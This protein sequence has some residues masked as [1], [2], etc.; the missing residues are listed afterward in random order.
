MI[1]VRISALLCDSRLSDTTQ[2]VNLTFPPPCPA[3]LT[4]EQVNLSEEELACD[5]G[6]DVG[7]EQKALEIAWG[8]P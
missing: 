5:A 1:R 7:D 2:D 3:K 6:K 8:Q 4:K